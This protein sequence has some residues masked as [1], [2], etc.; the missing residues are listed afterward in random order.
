MRPFIA[1]S[2][3][4][5]QLQTLGNY[6][7]APG[8]PPGAPGIFALTDPWFLQS[9]VEPPGLQDVELEELEELEI[10]VLEIA[11]GKAYLAATS[12]LAAPVMTL[13]NQLE[14][15]DRQ[16]YNAELITTADPLEQYGTLRMRGTTWIVPASK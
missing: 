9:I 3:R 4:S 11:D 16:R 5:N 14:D 15:S 8:P 7:D 2:A 13:V 1:R 10:N 6:M 12:D